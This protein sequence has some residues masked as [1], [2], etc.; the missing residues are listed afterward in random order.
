MT[1]HYLKLQKIILHNF[2]VK[3]DDLP[4]FRKLSRDIIFHFLFFYSSRKFGFL[5]LQKEKKGD[6]EV[7][8]DLARYIRIFF[9]FSPGANIE[10][11]NRVSVFI[12]SAQGFLNEKRSEVF[13]FH[14]NGSVNVWAAVTRPLNLCK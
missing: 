12:Y 1:E 3:D 7:I 4:S 10:Y 13:I 14:I 6:I 8:E 5:V 9:L 2:I 11:K